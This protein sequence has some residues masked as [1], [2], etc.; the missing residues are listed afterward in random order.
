[1]RYRS[2]RDLASRLF[3]VTEVV[4]EDGA[5]DLSLVG[6]SNGGLSSGERWLVSPIPSAGKPAKGCLGLQQSPCSLI[7][8][9]TR[10]VDLQF[11]RCYVV[12]MFELTPRGPST[13][14][15]P[16]QALPPN[17]A[18]Q[19]ESLLNLLQEPVSTES[20]DGYKER[21]NAVATRLSEIAQ[22]VK[23][24]E[25][26]RLEVAGANAASAASESSEVVANAEAIRLSASRFNQ[27][28][29]DLP[30]GVRFKLTELTAEWRQYQ[31]RGDAKQTLQG[32]ERLIKLGILEQVGVDEV[33]R[34]RRPVIFRTW[35][36]APPTTVSNVIDSTPAASAVEP[37]DE[38]RNPKV[39]TLSVSRF[40][41]LAFDLPIGV[42]FKVS[43]LVAEWKQY[44]KRGDAEQVRAR[45]WRLVNLGVLEQ[46]GEEEVERT[47]LPVTLR[48]R[49]GA[50]PAPQQ[51]EVPFASAKPVARSF[52]SVDSII[53]SIRENPS[54]ADTLRRA[55]H[56]FGDHRQ[57]DQMR[58]LVV[59]A[60]GLSALEAS[61]LWSPPLNPTGARNLIGALT[62]STV[63]TLRVATA[64]ALTSD[65][66]ELLTAKLSELAHEEAVR[67]S[68][69]D[70]SQLD[71]SAGH[72]IAAVALSHED[73]EAATAKAQVAF[74]LREEEI[75]TF[76]GAVLWRAKEPLFSL[77]K[78]Y[79]LP[80]VLGYHSIKRVEEVAE[81][82]LRGRT[83]KTVG[84]SVGV[85]HERIRQYVEQI[86]GIHPLVEA[87][88]DASAPASVDVECQIPNEI[89]TTLSDEI[90]RDP[91]T[92]HQLG[93]QLDPSPSQLPQEEQKAYLRRVFL[94]AF[95]GVYAD[96]QKERCYPAPL[97]SLPGGP[98][99]FFQG[100]ADECVDRSLRDSI[101]KFS[102]A[103]TD[104]EI[105]RRLETSGG[106]AHVIGRPITRAYVRALVNQPK[107]E[108][109]QLL[110][111][112][113]QSLGSQEPCNLF[114]LVEPVVRELGRIRAEEACAVFNEPWFA[115]W[116]PAER[117]RNILSTRVVEQLSLEAAHRALKFNV[118]RGLFGSGWSELIVR[119]PALQQLAPRRV[120]YFRGAEPGAES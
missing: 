105:D 24:S 34:T 57:E 94:A 1:M 30:I 50:L 104:D 89:L 56:A 95:A 59:S 102:R 92:A 49:P 19:L 52:I 117:L 114:A 67:R 76:V 33:Q 120:H 63:K 106:A 88:M 100:L 69:G 21:L 55:D 72:L 32:I 79:P 93:Q 47:R 40:N 51:P 18:N 83:L 4:S 78:N 101:E 87:I 41:Q 28:A 75:S 115:T 109:L 84:D 2:T 27:L 42:R 119:F 108:R 11:E 6:A 97:R 71:K 73:T 23:G 99:H 48:G 81:Y 110:R 68:V 15:S 96:G 46:V 61:K 91:Q 25:R 3:P 70:T 7:S 45:I 62:G 37:N 29:Y 86:A 38:A 80:S 20:L 5:G 112:L 53:Q 58:L 22:Q 64:R 36:V 44:Q 26:A 31:K 116:R 85:S 17:I 118:N 39:V 13:T 90:K 113:T 98:R 9:E 107:A 35:S 10:R 60:L 82:V 43:E 12:V 103:L 14:P 54:L 16:G 74:G 65:F 66:I 77:L 8:E 111:H